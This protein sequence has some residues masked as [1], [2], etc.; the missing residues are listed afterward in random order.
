MRTIPHPPYS[1][2]LAPADYWLF[3]VL[4]KELAGRTL[5]KET[6]ENEIDRLLQSIPENDFA[7]AF[8]K[9]IRRHEKCVAVQGANVEK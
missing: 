7:D 6:L 5:P 9:W 2:D 1:P 3:R 4:K 8:T